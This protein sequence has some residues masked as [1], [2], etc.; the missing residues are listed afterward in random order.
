MSRRFASTAI[1]LGAGR[2][3]ILWLMLREA[4]GLIAIGVA[5]GWPLAWITAKV[6][7][8]VLNGLGPFDRLPV[9]ASI[10]LLVIVGT[11]AAFIPAR[12]AAVMSPVDA[13]RR[14]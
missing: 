9:L 5:I 6:M 3:S 4:L 1:A 13:L 2:A 8:T 14:D 11:T 10:A 12:R 7:A